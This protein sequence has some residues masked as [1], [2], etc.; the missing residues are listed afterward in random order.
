MVFE[1]KQ[2]DYSFLKKYSPE[3]IELTN[4]ISSSLMIR[5]DV[6]DVS[7]FQSRIND[8]VLEFGLDDED[9]VNDIGKR[10]Y[11]IYDEL[12]YQKYE[13]KAP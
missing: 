10:L 9:T 7:E 12:L 6:A 8:S 13:N 5:F 2:S 11:N 4:V 3:S 1:L